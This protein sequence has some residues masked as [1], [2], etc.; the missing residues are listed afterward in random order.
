MATVRVMFAGPG[1]QANG[2]S[3]T[4]D[5]I[6]VCDQKDDRIYLI[7]Y[8]GKTKTSFATPARNLSGVGYGAGAVWGASN[9]T[10]DYV[11]K[12]DPW[13]G[14][15]TQ[16]MQ[17][18]LKRRASASREIQDLTRRVPPRSRRCENRSLSGRYR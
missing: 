17:S 10:P 5:G 12:F 13:T 16:A 9:H 14:H 7:D 18:L 6:W 8:D 2:L 3:A 1:P 15:C 11:Y 4:T